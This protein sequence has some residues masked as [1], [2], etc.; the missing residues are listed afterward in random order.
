M[1]PSA[2]GPCPTSYSV[3]TH[4]IVNVAWAGSL[5][6]TKG[7][8]EV[9]LWSK[10][11][12]VESGDTATVL[13]QSCG[14]SLPQ[15]KLSALAGGYSVLPQFPDATWDA[16]T[17]PTFKGTATRMPAGWQVRPGVALVGLSMADPTIKWPAAAQI[18][19][20]D[21]DS[22]GSPGITAFPKVG[23][24]FRAPPVNLAQSARVDELHL[25][26]RNVMTLT[27]NTAGCPANYTGVAEVTSFD[28]HIIGCHVEGGAVC[29]P[30]E[31]DF[32]DSNRTVYELLGGTFTSQRITDNA[33]CADIRGL[34]PIQ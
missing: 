5:A 14:S 23:G 25:A 24:T 7:T 3:A 20:V 17:M 9:H 11:Q 15:I 10:S 19:G 31:R 8:G 33:T 4:I 29:T 1:V 27:S 18:V 34:L 21:H 6:L 28:N 16:P 13:S 22:D 2:G 12:F 32:V 30:A 26:I